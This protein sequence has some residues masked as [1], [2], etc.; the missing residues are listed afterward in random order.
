MTKCE[1]IV[2]VGKCGDFEVYLGP[3]S[4]DNVAIMAMLAL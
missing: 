2:V 1:D 4:S 3:D